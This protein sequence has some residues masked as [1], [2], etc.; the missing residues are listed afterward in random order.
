MSV[1]L[2]LGW[3]EMGGHVELDDQIVQLLSELWVQ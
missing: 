1:I 3:T 2:S